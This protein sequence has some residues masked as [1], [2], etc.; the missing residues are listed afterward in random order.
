MIVYKTM[1]G[2]GIVLIIASVLFLYGWLGEF[3]QDCYYTTEA[4]AQYRL[5]GEEYAGKG[6]DLNFSLLIICVA[7]FLIGVILCNLKSIF[8]CFKK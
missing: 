6:K 5:C 7:L 2:L 3:D 8:W 4:F 1:K